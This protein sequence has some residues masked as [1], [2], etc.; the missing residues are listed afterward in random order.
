MV[1]LRRKLIRRESFLCAA[2]I[3]ATQ[4]LPSRSQREKRLRELAGY[5]GRLIWRYFL[6]YK[7]RNY[8]RFTIRDERMETMRDDPLPSILIWGCSFVTF[9]SSCLRSFV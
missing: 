6:L 3:L 7:R 4:Q 5:F 8:E 1:W 2:V 9:S